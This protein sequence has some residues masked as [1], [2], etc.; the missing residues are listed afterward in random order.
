MFQ[1]PPFC[2]GKVRRC[3]VC[4]IWLC[5][6][7]CGITMC[8]HQL[9]LMALGSAPV[10]F[11]CAFQCLKALIISLSFWKDS[12]NLQPV[13]VNQGY[14]FLVHKKCKVLYV[15]WVFSQTKQIHAQICSLTVLKEHFDSKKISGSTL[16]K[17]P[18]SSVILVSECCFLSPVSFLNGCWGEKS[19]ISCECFM[20]VS[21]NSVVIRVQWNC[22]FSKV[23]QCWEHVLRTSRLSWALQLKSTNHLT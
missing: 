2:A 11:S 15:S 10:F 5:S 14:C 22:T 23:E 18:I 12:F 3:L 19:K 20:P 8:F 6:R 9:L 17:V 13:T 21:C 16:N 1:I 7:A 4:A